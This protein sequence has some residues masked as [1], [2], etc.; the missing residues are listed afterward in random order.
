MEVSCFKISKADGNG[1][2]DECEF[3]G[4]MFPGPNKYEPK[5]SFHNFKTQ[6][7]KPRTIDHW[8]GKAPEK[9][10]WKPIKAKGPDIG[11]YESK[12]VFKKIK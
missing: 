12:D 2:L 7:T 8:V 10:G 1:F 11:S 5:V 9:K 3:N 4:K 6:L